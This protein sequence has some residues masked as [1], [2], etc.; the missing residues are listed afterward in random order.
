MSINAPFPFHSV[1]FFPWNFFQISDNLSSSNLFPHKIV[2]SAHSNPGGSVLSLGFGAFFF[3]FF[4]GQQTLP[5]LIS[6]VFLIFSGKFASP[7]HGGSQNINYLPFSLLF[8]VFILES[9]L[10]F[11]SYFLFG[12]IGSKFPCQSVSIFNKRIHWKEQILLNKI[13]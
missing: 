1:L 5:R 7:W 10:R 2:P 11:A 13:L 8:P 3:F 9:L 12:C 4:L 6:P